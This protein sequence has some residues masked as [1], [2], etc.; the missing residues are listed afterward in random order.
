MALDCAARRSLGPRV[1]FIAGVRRRSHRPPP[2]LEYEEGP[3]RAIQPDKPDGLPCCAFVDGVRRVDLHMFAEEE[4][5]IAPAM[6]GSWAVGAA[7]SSQPPEIADV[8]VDRVIVVGSGLTHPSLTVTIGG[9]DLDFKAESVAVKT[10]RELL[11]KLQ[12]MRDGE[13]A[14]A[15]A[16]AERAEADLMIQDGPLTYSGRG[17]APTIGLI[18]RQTQ[19]Y[20][21]P[22]RQRLLSVLEQGQ[23]TPLFRFES[24]ELPR[25]SWYARIASR[26]SIDGTMA[27][28]VRL[29]LGEDIGLE[30]ARTL[31]DL[32][33]ATLP[34][35]AAPMWRDSRSPQNLYPVGQLET[36][37][38]NRLGDRDLVRRGL[39][40][41]LWNSIH[42]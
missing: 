30:R 10:P 14:L 28:L 41:T 1:R 15:A 37:L 21:D 38:R 13:A 17:R 6:A 2:P 33:A 19:R 11:L 3:W 8:R 18:K 39:E 12:D 7:W 22:E 9:Q 32:T 27:G 26:R 24:R 42:G 23:R 35:F 31:A 40:S 34:R 16:V 29:E 36:I 25:F 20:L 5:M 4:D